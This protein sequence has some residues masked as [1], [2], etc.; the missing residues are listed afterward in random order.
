MFRRMWRGVPALVL[1]L[2]ASGCGQTPAAQA[3]TADAT[4]PAAT[5]APTTAPT[6][7]PTAA[8]L[9]TEA[10][11]PGATTAPEA[12]PEPAPEPAPVDGVPVV[13]PELETQAIVDVDAEDVP[14]GALGG[15]ADDPAIW[16]HP[17]DPALSVVVGV[18]K[19]G[20]LQVYDLDGQ[21]LQSIAP[22]GVRY[23]NIDLA[24]GFPLGGQPADLFVATDR[25]KDVLAVFR[26]DPQTRQLTDVTDP[27]AKLIF[28]PEGQESDEETTAYGIALYHSPKS[29]T[30]FAF[31]NRRATGD[32]A[33]LEL[34]D[35]GGRVGWRPVRSFTLPTPEGADEDAAQTEGM[36]ADQE[37]G[38][39]YIGQEDVGI[40]KFAAEPD[41]SSE[42]ALIH[43]V[44]PQ[45]EYLEADVEGL[46]IYY[47]AEGKGY[48]LSS[49]QGNNTFAVFARDGDN[50]YIGSFQISVNGDVDG[51]QESDGAQV[52]NLPLGPRFPNGLLVVQDGLNDPAVMVEDDGEFENAST[53]FKFVSWER[54]AQAFNPPLTI[55]TAT[56]VR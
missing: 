17:D 34:V 52:L 33:Q 15:D 51:S 30:F 40:W 27:A 28:T 24:Y 31:V 13:L 12:T 42:G 20:G 56:A 22:E 9:P 45:S 48:L 6:A 54:V 44:A 39:L 21:A 4:L 37:L 46:T 11:T 43:T 47:A 53:N 14:E 10:A 3:P 23:N 1:A 49:S 29:D 35:N 32:V 41:G 50:R 26:I 36:V 8:V 25:Y 38:A 19:D 55:D 18:L 2:A 7:A 16:V 5:G